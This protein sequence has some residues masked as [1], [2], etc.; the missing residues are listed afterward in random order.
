M[1]HNAMVFELGTFFPYR[2]RKFATTVSEAL[3][4]IYSV[5]YGLTTSE[6]R[7][8]AILG[9]KNILSASEIVERSSMDKVNVSRAVQSL[10]SRGYLK[11]DIDGDDRRKSVLRLTDEGIRVFDDLIPKVRAVE[12]RLLKDLSESDLLIMMDL[13]E[14]ISQRAEELVKQRE[15]SG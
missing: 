5:E 15:T 14:R 8:M 9:T 2:V 13:M 7:T 11:R 6:W 3:Q 1:G 4:Q 12:E 10:R